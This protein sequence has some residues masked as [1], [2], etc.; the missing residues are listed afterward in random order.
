MVDDE[1]Y[2]DPLGVMVRLAPGV[3]GYTVDMPDG[4]LNIPLIQAE[5]EGSGE[6]GRWIDALPVNR[7]IVFPTVISA[8]L[9]GMLE[10]RGYHPEQEWVE[11]FGEW[12][13]LMVRL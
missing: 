3:L 8:R 10:R 9:Q 4:S 6:V 2:V 1:P 13:N 12:A 5:H 7:R 11:E